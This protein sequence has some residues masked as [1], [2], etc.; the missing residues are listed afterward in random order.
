MSGDLERGARVCLSVLIFAMSGVV[1]ASRLAYEQVGQVT[2]VTSS[3]G[4]ININGTDYKLA[5]KVSVHAVDKTLG[6]T[7]NSLHKGMAVGFTTTPAG[8]S[9][10]RE[11]TSIW[12]L[13]KK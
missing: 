5:K 8:G 12:V 13:P 3:S 7:I 9:Q 11:V 4:E 6:V 10:K 1:H 2:S